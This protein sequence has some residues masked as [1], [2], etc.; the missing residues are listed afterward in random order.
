MA[1]L[2]AAEI[3]IL[4][5]IPAGTPVSAGVVR[6]L[7]RNYRAALSE[8]EELRMRTRFIDVTTFGDVQSMLICGNCGARHPA[9][10][11][12]GTDG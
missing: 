10:T 9:V 2:T 12:A 1:D 7:A 4:A 11:E 8:L 5:G 3:G 6:Q